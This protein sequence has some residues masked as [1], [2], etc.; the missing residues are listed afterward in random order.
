MQHPSLGSTTAGPSDKPDILIPMPRPGP[1]PSIYI[2]LSPVKTA[3]FKRHKFTH[4]CG[5]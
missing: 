2:C 1:E 3:D 5:C 4:F